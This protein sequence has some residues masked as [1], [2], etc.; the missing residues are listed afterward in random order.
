[1]TITLVTENL[2]VELELGFWGRLAVSTL[3]VAFFNVVRVRVAVST[4]VGALFI[5]DL[6]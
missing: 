2:L 1:M 4:I 3:V 6:L 5:V